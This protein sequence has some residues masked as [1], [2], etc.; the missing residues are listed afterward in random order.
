MAK[1]IHYKK[2]TRDLKNNHS[3]RKCKSVTSSRVELW[4]HSLSNGV[5][6][7]G[8]ILQVLHFYHVQLD[9][10][11]IGGQVHPHALCVH[12]ITFSLL[13]E[14]EYYDQ[15]EDSDE[16]AESGQHDLHQFQEEGLF[17]GDS[18]LSSIEGPLV[19]L[20]VLPHSVSVDA[21]PVHP[22]CAH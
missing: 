11:I 9:N 10:L 19:G 7:T 4:F 17:P 18:P 6:I 1:I 3:L 13:G 5:L 20:P 12:R 15:D 22:P 16:D 8:Q 21:Q 14:A 2:D